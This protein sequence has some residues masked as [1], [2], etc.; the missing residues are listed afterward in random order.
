M[1]LIIQFLFASLFVSLMSLPAH[2]DQEALR[3]LMAEAADFQAEYT[4]ATR[5][6]G[7]I[8][9]AKQDISGSELA[10]KRAMEALRAGADPGG[11][12]N[13]CPQES[14][15]KGIVA[16]CNAEG[17]KL[18]GWRT[19]LLGQADGRNKYAEQLQREQE[20]LNQSGLTWSAKKKSNEALQEVLDVAFH[21]WQRRY[22]TLV[23]KSAP[24][25]LLVS[26]E[27]G[28]AKCKNPAPTGREAILEGAQGC[29]QWLWVG[30]M[31]DR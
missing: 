22:A 11:Q 27:E 3:R 6:Q 2:A 8:E 20:R 14:A 21:S 7:Q 9:A 24:Y 28:A 4:K 29:L 10:L 31:Q 12:Q 17:S 18:D 13:R 16:A 23:F 19:H 26:T 25:S 30:A 1:K 15:S 5:T